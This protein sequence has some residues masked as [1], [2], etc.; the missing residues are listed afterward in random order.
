MSEIVRK[1]TDNLNY[2]AETSN[3]A[4]SLDEVIELIQQHEGFSGKPYLCP[5]GKL[6]IGYGRNLEANGIRKPEAD[7]LLLN[8]ILYFDSQISSRWH[9]YCVLP[10]KKKMVLIDMAYNLGINGLFNFKRMI[11]AIEAGDYIEASKEMLDSNW[12]KQVG[13][14]AIELAKMMEE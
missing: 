11:K 14:R 9:H 13:K 7:F 2:Y 4:N 5:A 12:A 6:T 3:I 1:I 10:P 8:D